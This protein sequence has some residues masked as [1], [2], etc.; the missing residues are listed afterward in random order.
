MNSRDIEKRFAI[1]MRSGKYT[2]K[3]FMIDI[4]IRPKKFYTV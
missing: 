3:I 1:R 2:E 4:A